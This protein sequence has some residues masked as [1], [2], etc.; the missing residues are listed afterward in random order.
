MSNDIY[1]EEIHIKRL[2]KM[3]KL[4]D[5]RAHCP[6][7]PYFDSGR[8][9]N[10]LWQGSTIEEVCDICRSFISLDSASGLLCPCLVLGE[11]KAKELTLLRLKEID[12]A[13]KI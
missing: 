4:N 6:A 1:T 9:A 2:K 7:A 13:Q 3:L 5:I 11:E 12:N 10:T 8:D